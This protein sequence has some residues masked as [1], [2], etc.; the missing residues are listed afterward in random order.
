MPLDPKKNV[1]RV[2][3]KGKVNVGSKNTDTDLVAFS[4]DEKP[5]CLIKRKKLQIK[6]NI[7]LKWTMSG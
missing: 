4:A 1:A 5:A 6:P 2:F 7:F 3:S